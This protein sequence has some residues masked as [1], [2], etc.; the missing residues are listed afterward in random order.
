VQYKSILAMIFNEIKCHV[1]TFSGLMG[2]MHPP[3][4][5]PRL[6]V[7]LTLVQCECHIGKQTVIAKI[8][9]TNQN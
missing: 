5:R 8:N 7:N 3:P 2:G 6:T 9:P 1:N 4:L